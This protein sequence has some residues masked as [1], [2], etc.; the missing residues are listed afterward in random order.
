MSGKVIFLNSDDMAAYCSY[1]QRILRLSH[2]EICCAIVRKTD[3]KTNSQADVSWTIESAR[4]IIKVMDPLD[5]DNKF[6]AQDHEISLVHELLHLH[7]ASFD[8][9]KV[10][11]LEEVYMER[12][13]E[14][15]AKA[16][17]QLKRGGETIDA[18]GK[19]ALFRV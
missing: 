3:L 16:L 8:I 14:H 5:Y 13:I 10:G 4:A 11:S 1:W 2:W 6:F 18:L 7:M 19:E 12:A 17:V 9:T 15:I